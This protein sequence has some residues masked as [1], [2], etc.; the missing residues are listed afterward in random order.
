MAFFA[1]A[2]LNRGARRNRTVF[3]LQGGGI[4]L[5]TLSSFLALF[6]RVMISSLNPAWNITIYNAASKLIPFT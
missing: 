2:W 1:A 4:A 5:L 3:F 6:P